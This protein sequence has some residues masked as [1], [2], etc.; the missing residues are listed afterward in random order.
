MRQFNIS[1]HNYC[2]KINVSPLTCAF[3]K[4]LLSEVPNSHT[5]KR[6]QCCNG[7][8]QRSVVHIKGTDCNRVDS[9]G[10]NILYCVFLSF[11]DR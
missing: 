1:A 7:A 8:E 5:L 10:S 3:H 6:E 11:L 9:N 2:A 4:P